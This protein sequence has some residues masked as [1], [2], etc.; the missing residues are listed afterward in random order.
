MGLL[1]STFVIGIRM[2]LQ[3]KTMK[4]PSIPCWEVRHWGFAG[5]TIQE[6]LSWNWQNWQMQLTKS[7]TMLRSSI[8]ESSEESL[9]E[10]AFSAFQSSSQSDA[11]CLGATRSQQNVS[12]ISSLTSVK[13]EFEIFF[14]QLSMK[15]VKYGDRMLIWGQ[16]YILR[17]HS[18]VIFSV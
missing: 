2:R 1:P 14:R 6:E 10:S 11:S 13:L 9:C 3:Q 16:Y 7:T 12:M 15:M 8:Q 18:V 4:T 17:G 5:I